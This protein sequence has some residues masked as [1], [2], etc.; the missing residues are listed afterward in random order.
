MIDHRELASCRNPAQRAARPRY[1]PGVRRASLRVGN[2]LPRS[3]RVCAV[4]CLV[5]LTVTVA[6]CTQAIP[7]TPLT[8]PGQLPRN[9][10]GV[11]SSRPTP[12]PPPSRS[13]L[14]ADVLPNECLLTADQFA[15]L[16]GRPVREPQQRS[17]QRTDGS[18]GNACYAEAREGPPTP[19]AAIN[20]YTVRSGTPA[21]FVRAAPPGGRKYLAGLGEAAAVI[22]TAIGPT[23]QLAGPRH[24]VT[25]VALENAPSDEAWRAAGEAALARLPG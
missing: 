16:V 5:L 1:R 15:A 21:D 13:G 14:D 18:V 2:G 4:L 10:P 24:L 6:A 8:A 17:V 11:S 20:V 9:P 19:L 3:G 22:D 7:G 12:Q 25:I 23:L